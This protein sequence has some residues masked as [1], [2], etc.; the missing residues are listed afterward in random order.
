MVWTTYADENIDLTRRQ[1][2]KGKRGEIF[3]ERYMIVEVERRLVDRKR[4]EKTEVVSME[5][6]DKTDKLASKDLP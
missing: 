3:E 1:E 4:G 6:L 5:G 2:V